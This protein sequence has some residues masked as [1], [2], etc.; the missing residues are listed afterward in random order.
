MPSRLEYWLFCEETLIEARLLQPVKTFPWIDVTPLGMVKLERLR[1]L[2]KAADDNVL[3]LVGSVIEVTYWQLSN[4][5]LPI[6]VTGFPLMVDG[7]V[8][9]P[10]RLPG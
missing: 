5:K 7:T 10:P 8:T 9:L 6:V 3:M 4:A 2:L 1:Q